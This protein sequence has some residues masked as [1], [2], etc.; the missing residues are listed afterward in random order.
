MGL[1]VWG[2]GCGVS[3]RHL[4]ARETAALAGAMLGLGK[5]LWMDTLAV[6]AVAAGGGSV[7]SPV[8]DLAP[9]VWAGLTGML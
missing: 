2:L 6:S 4:P 8:C 1:A 3:A 5:S 9:G 7:E